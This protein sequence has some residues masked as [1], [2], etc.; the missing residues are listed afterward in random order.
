MGRVT[1]LHHYLPCLIFAVLNLGFMLDHFI[2]SN[3]YFLERTRAIVFVICATAIIGV[4]SAMKLA[5][6]LLTALTCLPLF[7]SGGGSG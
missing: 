5:L 3:R 6:L 1:Y 4:A 2:L 7:Y